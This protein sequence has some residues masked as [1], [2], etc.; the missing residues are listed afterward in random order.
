M[1]AHGAW[2]NSMSDGQASM[3]RFSSL[4]SHDYSNLICFMLP[5]AIRGFVTEGVRQAVFKIG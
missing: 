5:I 1:L 2:N 3:V 4:K